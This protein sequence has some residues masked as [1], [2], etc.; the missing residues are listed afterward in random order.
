MS[1]LPTAADT[2]AFWAARDRADESARRRRKAAA[3]SAT[4]LDPIV[5]RAAIMRFLDSPRSPAYRMSGVQQE[6]WVTGQLRKH[7]L[8]RVVCGMVVEGLSAARAIATYWSRSAGD[9][10][11]TLEVEMACRQFQVSQAIG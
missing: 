6:S 4:Q 1:I 10:P 7:D 3:R 5:V 2:H 11:S 8:W 9:P